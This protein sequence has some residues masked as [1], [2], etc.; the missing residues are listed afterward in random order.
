[1]T[2]D[3]VQRIAAL[4]EEIARLDDDRRAIE[5][6]PLPFD[7]ARPKLVAAIRGPAA[8]VEFIAERFA[9]PNALPADRPPFRPT[10]SY[11]APTGVGELLALGLLHLDV[12]RVI[13]LASARLA[14]LYD[15]VSPGMPSSERPAA[16]AAIAARRFA[17]EEREEATIEE[18]EAAGVAIP[19]R[20][21]ADPAAVLG[22]DGARKLE[23]LLEAAHQ[24]H[25]VLLDA[26]DRIA[27]ARRGAG[28]AR[29]SF[30]AATASAYKN[31]ASISPDFSTQLDEAEREERRLV[32]ERDRLQNAWRDAGA[33]LPQL[34]A[35]LRPTSVDVDATVVKVA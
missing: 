26:E 30:E 35:Y 21:D 1:M 8:R 7:E 28:K 27:E 19:R 11:N 32:A 3:Y 22:A 16:L 33:I 14:A 31:H 13:E 6:A 17:L 20:A 2:T 15:T 12:E 29:A 34:K 23:R 9:D 24:R 5:R 10:H 4:R 18:S 25:V